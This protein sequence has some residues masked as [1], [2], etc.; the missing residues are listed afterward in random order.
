[1]ILHKK[2][3]RIDNEP[4]IRKC[5]R[6]NLWFLQYFDLFNLWKSLFKNLNCLF[7]SQPPEVFYNK[8]LFLKFLQNICKR[9]Y[10][11]F[12]NIFLEHLQVISAK[13]NFYLTARLN[14]LFLLVCFQKRFCKAVNFLNNSE[15]HKVLVMDFSARSR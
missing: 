2:S 13:A 7:Q 12:L 14:I 4:R 15:L 1:M 3:K 5:F 11:I 6:W 10:V 8:K 9:L